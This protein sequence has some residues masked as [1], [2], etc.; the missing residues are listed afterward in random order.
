MV[1]VTWVDIEPCE[2]PPPLRVQM[3]VVSVG[4]EYRARA[5][6]PSPLHVQM[7]LVPWDLDMLPMHLSSPPLDCQQRG[8]DRRT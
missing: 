2:S 3:V 4:Y 1:V 7:A 8:I 6:L 5:S